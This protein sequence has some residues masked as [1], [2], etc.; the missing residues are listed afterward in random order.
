MRQHG[1]KL[2]RTGVALHGGKA[3]LSPLP[4]HRVIAP[5]TRFGFDVLR[6]SAILLVLLSHAGGFVAG[7]LRLPFPHVLAVSGTFGVEL[8]FVLSGFLVGRI[9]LRTLAARPT[10]STLWRF[11]L[12]RWMRT[13]PLYW[14]AVLALAV[15]QPPAGGTTVRDVVRYASF[16]QNLLPP[17]LDWFFPVS[18][19]LAVEE[20]FYAGFALL[21]WAAGGGRRGVAVALG[22]FL[23]LP[24]VARLALFTDP[25]QYRIIPF[26]LD[27]IG[28]GVFAAAV[29]DSHPAAFR[30]GRR[31][32]GPALVLTLL[33]WADETARFTPA[34]PHRVFGF[35]AI[36]AALAL[37]L[38]A[39]EIWPAPRS[40]AIAATVRWLSTRSYGIYITHATILQWIDTRQPAWGPALS[41]AAACVAI[42]VVPELTWRLVERPFIAWRP[43]EASASGIAA[44]SST[45]GK[46][47]ET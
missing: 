14:L 1:V 20:W 24:P 13:L 41:A 16:T 10:R 19:T 11:L 25:A 3:K 35:G 7:W 39:A 42:G 23:A 21:L 26:W 36:A 5:R 44:S 31:L 4:P 38:P 22:T 29:A 2:R 43:A 30:W 18:W 37:L 27:C 9:L 45:S 15:L 46:I 12:R 28:W 33:F 6:A 40:R 47:G 34:W 32:A 17:Q 8:F